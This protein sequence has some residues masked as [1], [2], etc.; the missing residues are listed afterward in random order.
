MLKRLARLGKVDM[1]PKRLFLTILSYFMSLL[2]PIVAI[3][4]CG[5]WYS[6][7]LMRDQFNERLA[8]TLSGSAE[9][10]DNYLRTAQET[11]VNV[12]NDFTVRRLLMP[13]E[14]QTLEVRS[15]LWRLR[16]VLQRSENVISPTTDAIA[17]FVDTKDVYVGAGVNEFDFYFERLYRYEHYGAQFWRERLGA[18]AKSMELLPVSVVRQENGLGKPVVPIVLTERFGDRQ[19]VLIVN[20]AVQAVEQAL[21]GG[22]VFESTRFVVMD[23]DGRLLSDRSGM[24]QADSGWMARLTDGSEGQ[25]RML[26]IGGERFMALTHQ[27]GLFGWTYYSLTPLSAFNRHTNGILS[28]MLILCLVMI[29][30]GIVFSFIFSLRIYNPIRNLR[31]IVA[32]KNEPAGGGGDDAASADMFAL[33]RRGIDQLSDRREQYKE[34]QDKYSSEYV[35]YAMLFLIKGHTLNETDILRDTLRAQYGFDRPGFVC[36]AVYFEFKDVFFADIRDTERQHIV[37]GIKKILWNMLERKAPS[38]VMDYRNSVF[39]CL[40]NE[41]GASEVGRLDEV[42]AE[43]LTVFGY[44]I[45]KYYDIAIGIGRY[46]EPVNEIGTSYN[47]AMT[48]VSMRDKGRRFQ[49]VHAGELTIGRHYVYSLTDE[50]KMINLLKLGDED[51]LAAT[52]HDIVERNR[53]RRLSYEQMRQLFKD[54]QQTGNRFVAERGMEVSEL[55]EAA[56]AERTRML[57]DPALG[58]SFQGTVELER[59]M[60]RYYEAIVDAVKAR[61]NPESGSLALL[62]EQY[63]Q[64]HYAEDLGLE[65]IAERMGVSVKYVSRVFKR[66]FGVN[67]GDYLTRLRIDKAKELLELSDLR[68]NEVAE[69]VGIFSRSTFQRVF[70]KLEGISPNEYRMLHRKQQP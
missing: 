20:M 9:V 5:Y 25:V 59:W 67:L 48:A 30:M 44:D 64:E 46:C 51:A 61:A 41:R 8:T 14:Q 35:E 40:V 11:G 63:I 17:L 38:Y 60:I 7:K 10:V 21:Q 69:R 42:F 34:L 16:Q 1:K 4:T 65:Q 27:S 54:M 28:M 32:Q 55:A 62:I 22:A 24:A 36:C 31:D 15:E 39:V 43:L 26:E 33:I 47:E 29:V 58:E 45:Q 19:P 70:K 13:R 53:Q 56:E 18:G 52:V 49:I 37:G 50:Q 68:M 12:L 57:A 3:G 6:V 23:G 2:I 66:K